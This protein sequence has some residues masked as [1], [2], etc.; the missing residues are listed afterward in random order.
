MTDFS[1]SLPLPPLN[2]PPSDATVQ[3]SI[4]DSTSRVKGLP[5]K[6]FFQPV[7]KGYEVV[8]CPAFSFLIE[9]E[10][11]GKKLLFDL[12]VAK[13]WRNGPPAIA[14]RI[15]QNN[16]D[17]TVRKNVSDILAEHGVPLESITTIIWSHYHWDHTGDPSLF[18]PT[19]SLTVG[20]GFTKSQTPGYP[21]NPDA[22]I[23]ESAYE[24]RELVEIH[25][26]EDPELL[27]GHFRAYDYFGDGSF[28]LLDSPGH[29][30]GHIC[31][32]ARTTPDTFVL[33]G[34]DTCHHGGQLR[35]TQY[36]PLP[37]Y[38]SPN[39]FEPQGPPCPGSVLLDVHPHKNGTEPYFQIGGMNGKSSHDDP[40]EARRSLNKLQEFDGHPN[41]LTVI[42]HDHSLLGLVDLYPKTIN[43]WYNKG[44]KQ[45]GLWQFARDFQVAVRSN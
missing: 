45:L 9:H 22:L 38:I 44:Y 28:Y 15:L 11:T 30:I 10:S 39:P 7:I 42:A 6:L 23:L 18:P 3:V 25:F 14:N 35:P 37:D 43:D 33:M 4:I 21:T 40:P 17:V 20:P 32:L 26:G 34:G 27:L 36:L 29:A 12:G 13:D 16:W 41:V 8:D 5:T 2:I 19:T 31:G 24:D 1:A